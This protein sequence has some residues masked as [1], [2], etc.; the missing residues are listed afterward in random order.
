MNNSTDTIKTGFSSIDVITGGLKPSEILVIA[1][2]G[3]TGKTSLALSIAKNVA[4][5]EKTPCAFFS[6]EMS[7]VKL[8]NRLISN[9]CDIDGDKI[10]NGQLNHNEWEKLDEHISRLLG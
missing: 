6:M 2:Q 3:R 9:V 1:G 8:V 4:V 10:L 5:D 7:N